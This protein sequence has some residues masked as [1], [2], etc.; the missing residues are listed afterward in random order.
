MKL[1]DSNKPVS[2]ITGAVQ[3]GV[4]M[5]DPKM[6]KDLLQCI[7]EGSYVGTPNTELLEKFLGDF[8]SA[9]ENTIEKFMYHMDELFSAG[10]FRAKH[11]A[12]EHGWGA[13]S[14]IDGDV[15][16]AET[17]LVLSPVGSEVLEELS[18]PKGL[19]SFKSA[20]RNVGVTSAV[21]GT[22]AV[23]YAIGELLKG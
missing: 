10:L 9:D 23:K 21:A 22:E 14:G 20:I 18:K 7:G 11:L 19:E 1:P 4:E 8:D 3:D 2:G 13:G 15:S 6:M 16:I 17:N 5:P 12:V